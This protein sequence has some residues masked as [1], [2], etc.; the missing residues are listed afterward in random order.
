M[1]K[2][3]AQGGCVYPRLGLFQG[4]P[5]NRRCPPSE[6]TG[7]P[8]LGNGGW[9][10]LGTAPQRAPPPSGT[11]HRAALAQQEAELLSTGKHP[12]PHTHRYTPYHTQLQGHWGGQG[13]PA[14][15]GLPLTACVTLG[16]WLTFSL[17]LNAPIWRMGA[18][19][20]PTSAGL[21]KESHQFFHIWC[22]DHG[23]H[24]VH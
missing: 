4:I 22:L 23:K 15:M 16:G 8:E 21:L 3:R 9:V 5:N 2:G 10:A 17:H 12:P 14:T 1:V 24:S 11:P 19:I 13:D 7:W 20:P 6:G 18:V